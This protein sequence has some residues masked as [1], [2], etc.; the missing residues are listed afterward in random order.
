MYSISASF[1]LATALLQLATASPGHKPKPIDNCGPPYLN[2]LAQQHG[3]L[4][5]GTAAD[6]PGTNE[7][8]DAGYMAIV[9]NE[10]IFGELTPANMMKVTYNSQAVG[11]KM[12]GTDKLSQFMYTEPEQNVFNYTGM[13]DRSFR[14]PFANIEC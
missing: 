11:M 4:W 6:I 3:K 10:K 5:L 8:S 13:Q 14:Y 2:E 7:T 9:T 12:P 1:V